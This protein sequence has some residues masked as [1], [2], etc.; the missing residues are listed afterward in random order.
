MDRKTARKYA[1]SG[2][3]PSEQVTV[4]NWRTREDPFA[5]DWPELEAML[6]ATPGLE[7]K[8]LFEALCERQPGVHEPGECGRCSSRRFFDIRSGDRMGRTF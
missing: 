6:R 8:T 3:L 7:A 4:R 5:A 1:A 2:Q